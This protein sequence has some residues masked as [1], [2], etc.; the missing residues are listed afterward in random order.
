MAESGREPAR[1]EVGWK[2]IE[3][4]A[5]VV[6]APPPAASV[7]AAASSPP[8]SLTAGGTEGLSGTVTRIT[9]VTVIHIT[10]IICN[11]D[12]RYICYRRE[13]KPYFLL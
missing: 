11:S 5:R 6:A 12:T 10:Y 9:Y 7:P 4:A 2:P 13:V 8:S 3:E 1:A